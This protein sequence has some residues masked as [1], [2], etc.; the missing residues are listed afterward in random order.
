MKPLRMETFEEQKYDAEL[1]NEGYTNI[2]KY[3]ICF[4]KKECMVRM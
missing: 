4:Y 3:G 1:R 2:L